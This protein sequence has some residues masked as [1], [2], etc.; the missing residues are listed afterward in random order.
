MSNGVLTLKWWQARVLRDQLD[1]GLTAV[2][3]GRSGEM[4]M[5]SSTRIR[6]DS[7]ELTVE[8]PELEPEAKEA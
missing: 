1:A 6:W 4:E 2:K 5:D 3:L 8:I 7:M